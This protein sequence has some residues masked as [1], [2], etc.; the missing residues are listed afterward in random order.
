MGNMWMLLQD[1]RE[2]FRARK[3]LLFALEKCL[4]ANEW[5]IPKIGKFLLVGADR[6]KMLLKS[7]FFT[8]AWRIDLPVRLGGL[9]H[10]L[11]ENPSEIL[12]LQ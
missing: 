4:N 8:S 1:L 5:I 11:S 10:C 6:E 9:C 3:S 2:H 7:V 12:S